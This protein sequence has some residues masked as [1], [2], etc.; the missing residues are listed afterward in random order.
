MRLLRPAVALG[1]IALWIAPGLLA[2]PDAPTGLTPLDVLGAGV[3]PALLVGALVLALSALVTRW[4]GL[5]LGRPQGR[6][7]RLLW[8]PALY[9]LLFGIGAAL[10]GS[11]VLPLLPVLLLN[12]ALVGWIEEAL[13]RGFLYSGLRDVLRPWPAIL[14]S[15]AL[16]GL[17]HLP[18]A[19]WT[20]DL[21]T[22]GLQA[23]VT[24]GLGLTF[25][26]IRL[27]SGSLWPPVLL[28]AAWNLGLLLLAV[29]GGGQLGAAPQAPLEAGPGALA[30]LLVFLPLPLYGLYLLRHVGRDGDGI[31][32]LPPL[33][34]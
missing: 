29:A 15:S 19:A 4:R 3:Q 10:G 7:W 26:A 30:S 20:G 31:A 5:G 1:L 14:L 11:A 8:L 25:I 22:A 24:A 6:T 16:F 34:R 27:R 33:A 32:T 2:A 13:F 12:T 17:A 23:V 18:N 28:H 21:G 9:I